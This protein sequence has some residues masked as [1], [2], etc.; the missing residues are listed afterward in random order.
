MPQDIKIIYE[1]DY[2]LAINKPGTIPVQ[3]D[4]TNDRSLAEMLSDDSS[5]KGREFAGL[6]HRLDRP[7]SG[8]VIFAKDSNTLALM[9]E[10]FKKNGVKKIYLAV[11]DCKPPSDNGTLVHYIVK[12]GKTNRSTAFDD[13]RKDAKKAVLNYRLMGKSDRYYFLEIEL[14]TG[15]HHQIRAQ[16]AAIGCHIK[17]DVKYGFRRQN[18]DRSIHLH[19]RKLAFI[20]PILKN[21]IVITA[22]PPDDPLWNELKKFY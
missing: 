10:L 8:I 13:E 9:N 16:L 20:H 14:M 22:E 21:E 7:V 18:K 17:G 6:I 2:L 12:N 19:A 3:K 15:R 4:K 5:D 1:D 11:V